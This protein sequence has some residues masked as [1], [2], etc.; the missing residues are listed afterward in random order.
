MDEL[1]SAFYFY[2]DTARRRAA[3]SASPGSAERYVLFGLDQEAARGTS[4][5]HN[6]GGGRPPGWARAADRV[7]R[8][9]LRRV[10]GTGGG[11]AGPLAQLGAANRSDV[12][13]ATSDR[14]G[15]PLTLL[16]RARLL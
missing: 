15:M 8:P 14:L 6:L 5:G 2:A 10:G 11:L 9:S 3:L 13:V 12:V 4:V 1:L 16:A 7:A